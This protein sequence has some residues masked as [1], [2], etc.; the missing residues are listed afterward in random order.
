MKVK[1]R[2][3]YEVINVFHAPTKLNK[4]KFITDFGDFTIPSDKTIYDVVKMLVCYV[5]D[6]EYRKGRDQGWE[7]FKNKIK[8]LLDL[9]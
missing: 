5:S 7:D 6:S 8:N 1:I 3:E 9:D 4:N 2:K